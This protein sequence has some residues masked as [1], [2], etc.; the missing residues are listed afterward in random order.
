MFLGWEPHPMNTNFDMGY[1]S[2]ADDY[3]GP[4]YGGAT[5]YTN[6]RAGYSDE[7]T[8]VG[9]L[10]NNLSFT[11]AMENQVMGAIMDDGKNEKDAARAW[12]KAHP[13]TLTAWLEGVTTVDGQPGL[14]AVKQSLGL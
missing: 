9:Q 2:G 10:L 4:D 14:P 5:V 12:L 7:C 1:L 6:T 11:L 8:N 13:D 3:F